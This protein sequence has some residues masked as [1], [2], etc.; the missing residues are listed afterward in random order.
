MGAADEVPQGEGVQISYTYARQTR[1]SLHER[2][3]QTP[4]FSSCS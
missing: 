2:V 3:R 1:V 4:T